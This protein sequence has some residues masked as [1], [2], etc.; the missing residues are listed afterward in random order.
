MA[1]VACRWCVGDGLGGVGGKE[2][3]PL[4]VGAALRRQCRAY[5]VDTFDA[6]GR[7]VAALHI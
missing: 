7:S 1:L 3:A 4:G 5:R 6:G 2:W